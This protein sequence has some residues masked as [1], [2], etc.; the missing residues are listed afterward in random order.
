MIWWCQRN[1]ITR[2]GARITCGRLWKLTSG[3]RRRPRARIFCVVFGGL[4]ASTVPG[5][6]PPGRGRRAGGCFD[7]RAVPVRPPSRQGLSLR[8]TREPLRLWFQAMW[9]F[10]NQKHGVSALGLQRILGLGSYQTAWAWAPP[11][12]RRLSSQPHPLHQEYGE[13]GGT[14]PYGRV[15]RLPSPFASRLSASPHESTRYA[16]ACSRGDAGDGGF[17]PQL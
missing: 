9:Y 2:S 3:S 8:G 7:A 1:R 14:C 5:A 12:R 11:L 15:G 10:T 13:R 16:P 6:V 4:K 17:C